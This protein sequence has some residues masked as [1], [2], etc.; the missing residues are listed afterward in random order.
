M[1]HAQAAEYPRVFRPEY[2]SAVD[3][4]ERRPEPH[5]GP[6]ACPPQRERVSVEPPGVAPLPE[7]PDVGGRGRR[8]REQRGVAEFRRQRH[9]APCLAIPVAE[10][11]PLSGHRPWRKDITS[12]PDI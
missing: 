10:D 8:Y 4:V 12:D 7:N 1:P 9:R 11:G 3:L 6:A 2:D 5:H